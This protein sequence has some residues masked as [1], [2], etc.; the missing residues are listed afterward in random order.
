MSV[1]GIEG[2]HFNEEY[3]RDIYKT[4]TSKHDKFANKIVEKFGDLYYEKMEVNEAVERGFSWLD[5]SDKTPKT[6]DEIDCFIR[7][8]INKKVPL[9]GPQWRAIG[10]KFKDENHKTCAI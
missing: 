6:Y 2:E 10:M 8:N 5:Y 7:D 4:F 9:D 1:T 3:L